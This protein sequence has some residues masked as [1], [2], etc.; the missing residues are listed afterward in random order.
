[1][2]IAAMQHPNKM[3]RASLQ[4][5]MNVRI[6][7]SNCGTPLVSAFHGEPVDSIVDAMRELLSLRRNEYQRRAVSTVSSLRNGR[8]GLNPGV[9]LDSNRLMRPALFIDLKGAGWIWNF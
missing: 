8:F 1:M 4:C 2:P 9:L 3:R 5:I 7:S 6:N